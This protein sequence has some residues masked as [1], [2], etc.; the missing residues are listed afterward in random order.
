MDAE[1]L[2]W[3]LFLNYFIKYNEDYGKDIVKLL[4]SE[5]HIITF[6]QNMFL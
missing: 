4:V 5:I 6:E 3:T 2:V 1:I